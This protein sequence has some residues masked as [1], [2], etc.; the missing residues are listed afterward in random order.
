MA[1][2]RLV[3]DLCV[4]TATTKGQTSRDGH[5]SSYH[6]LV[7]CVLG[8]S[9]SYSLTTGHL[10]RLRGEGINDTTNMS[11]TPYNWTTEGHSRHNSE[12][13]RK[14]Q[15]NSVPSICLYS[16]YF[17]HQSF[18]TVSI[19]GTLH[20]PSMRLCGWTKENFGTA[21]TFNIHCSPR[22]LLN[23]SWVAG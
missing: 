22:S 16:V 3:E 10:V 6:I 5:V 17:N 1:G 8:I 23:R 4:G 9:S 12:P 15:L 7:M 20:R 11:T 19:G 21:R 14:K 2:W 13:A 18:D